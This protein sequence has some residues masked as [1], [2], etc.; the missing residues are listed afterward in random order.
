[1]NLI[2]LSITSLLL[3]SISRSHS[4]FI[5]EDCADDKD[6]ILKGQSGGGNK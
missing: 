3:N 1:M 6:A 5:C 2:P 4:I